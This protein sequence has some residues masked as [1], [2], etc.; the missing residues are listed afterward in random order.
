MPIIDP[1][2]KKNIVDPF[3]E[4]Q[5]KQQSDSP[6][7]LEYLLGVGEL[8]LSLATG[9][10][11]EP[12]S[13]FAGM[14][15]PF[16]GI[17]P[18]RAVEKTQEM[19]T[20]QP[21]SNAA[22]NIMRPIAAI[23]EP[24]GKAVQGISDIA[25]EA[26]GPVA[27]TATK[28]LITAIPDLLGMKGTKAAKKMVLERM[29]KGRDI[30]YLY[31][32]VGRLMPE[33]KKG[34]ENAGI[35]P[36]DIANI[37]PENIVEAEKRGLVTSIKKM[38]DVA[39]ESKSLK[40]AE[41]IKPNKEIIDAAKDMG[42]SDLMLS[43]HISG[44]PTYVAIEQGLKSIPGSML[45][46]KEKELVGALSKKADD[47][48]SEFGGT[49]DKSSLSDR[50]RTES[51]SLV[52]G[53][54][55]QAEYAFD[56]LNNIV[57]AK[58]PAKTNNILNYIYNRA[59]GLGGFDYLS[60]GEKKILKALDAKTSPTYA[61]LD[62]IRK[63]IGSGLKNNKGIF[64][65]ASEGQ[66]KKLYGELA[67]DQLSTLEDI[68]PSY[69]HLYEVGNQTV[70]IRKGIEDQLKAVVGSDISGDITRKAG[71]A[72]NSLQKGQTKAWDDLMKSIPQ[73]L[74]PEMKRD[75]IA[76]SL[77]DA[78][79]QGGRTNRSL[80]ISGFDNWM[81]GLKKYGGYSRLEKELGK[82]TMSRLESFHKVVSAVN[83]A[84]KNAITTGRIAAVPG[85]FDE[86]NGMVDRLY[87]VGEKGVKTAARFPGSGL[88][89]PLISV[90]K[91]AKSEIADNLLA[92]PK[93]RKI[94]ADKAAGRIDTT[95]KI[96]RA[97]SMLEDIKK[98]NEW[99]KSLDKASLS[100]LAA[101]GGVGYL[102]GETVRKGDSE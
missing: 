86:V 92:S 34:I 62:M 81:N 88:L 38:G 17:D 14:T 2:E 22:M 27:G 20:Y 75:I 1:F 46:S 98:Y 66:L 76:T 73:D 25:Y 99:K 94:I 11:S 70:I 31:D 54:E 68:D 36:E 45:A 82:D 90:E 78:F 67:K 37:I 83:N 53:L 16:S 65:D 89:S 9:A 19:F 40:I 44:N 55:E 57:Q 41:D 85:M 26:G 32:D 87:K 39:H 96:K 43:S 10:I 71:T 28:T 42:V 49:I 4:A 72:I 12:V 35:N 74:G 8:G 100:D 91:T 3:G 13:G 24:I 64:K 95:E 23:S 84:Q 47:L 29:V 5:E 33:I 7:L 59:D 58:T 51:R 50:F 97:E 18:S 101:I 102:T 61:R 77:N 15:A 56:T 30:S 80:N 63:E 93:F 21:R 69:A 52:K 6:G 48:I 60:K 79:V